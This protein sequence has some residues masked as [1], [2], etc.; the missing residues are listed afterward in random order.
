MKRVLLDQQDGHAAAAVDVG[1]D[2]EDLLDD[3]RRQAERGLVEQQQP[4]PA[5]QGAGDGKHL[6][7]AAG[8]GT[9]A[10][11]AALGEDG[12]RGEDRV[13]VFLE[14][15][16]LA[17][18][19][20]HLQI[21]QHRHAREDAPA[22]G[23]LGKAAADD[24]EGRQRRDLLAFEEHAPGAG[25]GVAANGHQQGRFAGA[26][27]PDQGDDLAFAHGQVDAAQ[28]LDGAVMAV[29]AFD[30]KHHAAPSSVSPR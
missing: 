19:C 20:A 4:R 23:G 9:A 6:L 22:F 28:G 5:H 10:L 29:Y 27:G 7:L 21:L 1:D 15:C 26:V 16:F 12:E 24:L 17:D 3:Q 2:R 25:V 14:V 18:H 30:G 11:A 13:E 8:Q